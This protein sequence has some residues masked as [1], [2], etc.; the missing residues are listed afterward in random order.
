MLLT[1]SPVRARATPAA[2]RNRGIGEQRLQESQL[3][4]ASGT[5]DNIELAKFR[6]IF[7]KLW[8]V[9]P[10]RYKPI[11]SYKAASRLVCL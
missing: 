1:G 9:S 8:L 3:S 5:E 2:L 11:W 7:Q 10:S 4:K 6:S